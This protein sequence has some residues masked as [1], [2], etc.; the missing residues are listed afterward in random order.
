MLPTGRCPQDA[1]HRTLPTGCHPQ[2]AAHR[3][4]PTGRCSQ[5]AA[6]RTLPTGCCPQDAA[7]RHYPQDAAH[8]TLPTG[9]CLQDAA[10]RTL[11]IGRCCLLT[12]L[13]GEVSSSTAVSDPLTPA[14]PRPCHCSAENNP[15]PTSYLLCGG[16]VGVLTIEEQGNKVYRETDGLQ[17]VEL[18]SV[19]YWWVELIRWTLGKPPQ[20]QWNYGIARLLLYDYCGF[21]HTTH[22]HL[23]SIPLWH[24]ASVIET[25]FSYVGK[26]TRCDVTGCVLTRLLYSLFTPAMGTVFLLW[27]PNLHNQV[28]RMTPYRRDKGLIR[29][30]AYE[31]A[32][33]DESRNQAPLSNPHRGAE[34][35]CG[36]S[37]FK[38]LG[39]PHFGGSHHG[40]LNSHPPWSER[41]SSVFT[42][43]GAFRKLTFVPRRLWTSTAVAIESITH[44]TASSLWYAS[45]L[46]IGPVKRFRGEW[47]HKVGVSN[48]VASEWKYKVG[49]SNKVASE[50]KYSVGVSNKVAS[51]WKHRG[52]VSD[53][54]A[55]EWKHKVGVSNKVASEWKHKRGVSNKVASEWKHKVG[56]SNKVAS[57]WKHKRG[58]SN[59]VASEWKHK[60]GVSNKVASEWK[61][62]VGVSNKVASEWK[63]KVGVSDKV[64]SE[65]KHKGGVSNKVASEWK[66]KGGVSNKVASEWK[67]KVGVSNKVASEWKHK[68]GVS[69]KVA[70]EWKHKVGVSNKVA[71]E[72][73]YKVGI[74]NKVASEWKHKVGVSNKVASEWKYKVGVSNKVA[75][76]WKH[77]PSA[78]GAGTKRTTHGGQYC[79][80]HVSHP[81]C[82]VTPCLADIPWAL[83][84]GSFMS[85]VCAVF[86]PLYSMLQQYLHDQYRALY[87]DKTI[88]L[89]KAMQE[90]PQSV[91]R[92]QTHPP[93]FM[94]SCAAS[95]SRDECIMSGWFFS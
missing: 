37:N 11:P 52:G 63:Y 51:E 68:V 41:R 28:W 83:S 12:V 55:S 80:L 86:Y 94:D 67:H 25:P 91:S 76:E 19:L 42:S 64:A 50:W 26:W 74:S 32:Y 85:P 15:P 71:S 2:D 78:N 13:F 79:S 57:E 29:G 73:K 44:K 93:S 27:L 43:Y 33:R 46:G 66:H 35:E 61:H 77:K 34:V 89:P 87:A 24:C 40:S 18:Q 48:K 72:W 1:T 8:R 16:P 59:K 31:T 69:D 38:F 30:A 6:H 5:D 65:W 3:T 10:H 75:S 60:R 92:C 17:S 14:T 7:H 20:L 56:V 47:K 4:L 22:S 9:H 88:P 70:S 62:K 39:V 81:D 54:V 49:V 90:M 84:L 58:V 23:L 53:K 21:G 95:V 45:L 82:M 36:L